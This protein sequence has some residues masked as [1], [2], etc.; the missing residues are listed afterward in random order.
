MKPAASVL[1]AAMLAVYAPGLP[2]GVAAQTAQTADPRAGDPAYERSQRLF[3]AIRDI[4]EDAAEARAQAR[5]ADGVGTLMK[6]PLGLDAQS[7]A[8]RLLADAFSVVA[9]APVTQ[10][11]REI[12]TRRETISNLKDRMARLREDRISAPVES[13]LTE[14]LG[15]SRTR[16]DIDAD[17]A[18][19]QARIAANEMA[20]REAKTRFRNEMAEA[21]AEISAE[22]ADLLIDSVTGEDIVKIASAYQAARGV[23]RQLMELMD[24]SGEDLARAKRYYAMHTA[25]LALLVHAQSSFI[26]TVDGEY[27][28]KLDAIEGDILAAR[29]ET[30]RL[31]GE[32]NTQAQHDALV[33]NLESQDIAL[34]A[35]GFY[36]QHL[37]N[38]RAEIEE[39]RRKAIKELRIAD[40]TLRTVDASFQLRAMM[41]SATL[42]FEAL[43]SMESPGI[44][45]I[46]RNEQLRREF[47][48]LSERLAPGS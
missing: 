5:D 20:V 15:L 29:G 10:I 14:T 3:G 45:R 11:Q 21:G 34:E 43:Q 18:E 2:T 9:D 1:I 17:I 48:E 36:R 30:E 12:E 37:R 28:P 40:N 25:L 19:A 33:G 26:R 7:R 27:L 32:Q 31:L 23:S 16:A 22:E 46:F 41:E 13:G 39:A 24:A 47:Q 6:R 4:L 35:A 8:E 38:Q 42:S 44:E